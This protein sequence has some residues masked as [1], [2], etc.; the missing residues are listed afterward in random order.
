VQDWGLS[1]DLFS[2]RCPKALSVPKGIMDF[3]HNI[4]L[5]ISL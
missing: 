3:W 5:S 4:P 2:E 1:G